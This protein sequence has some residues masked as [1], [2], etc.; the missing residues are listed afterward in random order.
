MSKYIILKLIIKLINNNNLTV[1]IMTEYTLV[2]LWKKTINHEYKFSNYIKIMALDGCSNGDIIANDI[3]CMVVKFKKKSP[4]FQ[5]NQEFINNEF[6]N[7]ILI[8][9]YPT[10]QIYILI[11]YF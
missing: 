3:A 10:I 9:T 5:E 4:T 8:Y 11:Y 2:K 1:F 7:S 6:K